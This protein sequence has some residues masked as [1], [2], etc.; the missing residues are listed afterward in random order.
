MELVAVIVLL[1]MEGPVSGE[2]EYPRDN[3]FLERRKWSQEY[4]GC[5]SPKSHS[6]CF[7]CWCLREILMVRDTC[8]DLGVDQNL[9]TTDASCYLFF[10]A[11]RGKSGAE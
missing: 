5:C 7:P 4:S 9:T 8:L 10:Q 3:Q 1:K 6:D 2:V 11:P